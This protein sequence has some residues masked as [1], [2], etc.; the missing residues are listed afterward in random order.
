MSRPEAK[1]N[2]FERRAVEAAILG[3]PLVSVDAMRQPCFWA[4][5]YN[6]VIFRSV[7]RSLCIWRAAPAACSGPDDHAL[8]FSWPEHASRAGYFAG[9]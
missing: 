3:V 2:R 9:R 7:S 1:P 6:D 4:G 5:E 8:Q